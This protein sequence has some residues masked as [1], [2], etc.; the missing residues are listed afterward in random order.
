MK[1][2]QQ[3]GGKREPKRGTK[4]IFSPQFDPHMSFTP[5]TSFEFALPC[6]F[7]AHIFSLGNSSLVKTK[8]CNKKL[9][10]SYPVSLNGTEFL[11]LL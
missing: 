11:S 7:T 8:P 9:V 3:Q 4:P 2:V 5:T 1:T 6:T 10:N